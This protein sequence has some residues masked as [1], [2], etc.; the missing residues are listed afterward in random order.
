MVDFS[1][2]F[3]MV[4]TMFRDSPMFTNQ[5]R[6]KVM[7]GLT[8]LNEFLSCLESKEVCPEPGDRTTQ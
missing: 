8:E 1:Y 2:A 4:S 6:L 7:I 3:G 5:L